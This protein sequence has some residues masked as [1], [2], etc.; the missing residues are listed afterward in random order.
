MCR[1]DVQSICKGERGGSSCQR[2][3]SPLQNLVFP[4][5]CRAD[6]AASLQILLWF[7]NS[8]S[9]GEFTAA[10]SFLCASRLAQAGQ[11][12]Q[13]LQRVQGGARLHDAA[14][15]PGLHVVYED[16]DLACIVK[17]QGMPVAVWPSW[18]TCMHCA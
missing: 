6:Q 13:W 5:H 8:G 7:S 1:A 10:S 4:S 16:A 14:V 17:P 2:E 15:P 18:S 12:V 3:L 11:Q 9:Q